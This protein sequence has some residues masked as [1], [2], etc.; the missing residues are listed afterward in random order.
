MDFLGKKVRNFKALLL[1]GQP[2]ARSTCA[3]SPSLPP[4]C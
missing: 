2:L 1:F 4:V 3:S